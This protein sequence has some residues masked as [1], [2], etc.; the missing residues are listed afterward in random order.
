MRNF[1]WCYYRWFITSLALEK[2]R[3]ESNIVWIIL[4]QGFC[5]LKI[6]I[7]P[8]P[9][10]FGLKTSWSHCSN[11]FSL[12]FPYKRSSVLSDLV[13]R[14]WLKKLTC[15]QKKKLHRLFSSVWKRLVYCSPFVYLY[16]LG[17]SRRR[18]IFL[19]AATCLCLLNHLS[20]HDCRFMCTKEVLERFHCPNVVDSK[21]SK[22]FNFLQ[23]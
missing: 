8:F 13:N 23:N 17:K 11:L 14:S 15:N 10:G 4:V 7:T 22:S 9:D 2:C 3:N 18:M 20:V 16:S 1:V 12:N 6:K 5:P 21:P 19:K